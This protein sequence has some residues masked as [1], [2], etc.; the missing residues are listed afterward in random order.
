[1]TDIKFPSIGEILHTGTIVV[2][3]LC[4]GARP[5]SSTPPTM[6]MMLFLWVVDVISGWGLGEYKCVCGLDLRLDCLVK[7]M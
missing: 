6:K 7:G 5:V 1:M 3:Y 2:L 4:P